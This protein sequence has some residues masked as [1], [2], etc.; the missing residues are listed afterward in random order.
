MGLVPSPVAVKTKKARA[1]AIKEMLYRTGRGMQAD[2][3]SGRIAWPDHV[4]DAR[5][6]AFNARN[7]RAE[8]ELMKYGIIPKGA[9][10]L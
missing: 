1:L 6:A 5:K 10:N 4:I 9:V 7:K 2:Y 3:E 8:A